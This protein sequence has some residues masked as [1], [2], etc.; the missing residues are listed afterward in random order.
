MR[1][2]DQLEER[3]AI[4]VEWR[5][6]M[7]GGGGVWLCVVMEVGWCMVVWSYG[8]GVVWVFLCVCFIGAA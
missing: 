2:R 1:G 4:G 7:S 8:C 5:R 6:V 3:S